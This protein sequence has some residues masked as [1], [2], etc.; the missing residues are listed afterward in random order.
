MPLMT[1]SGQKLLR[2]FISCKCKGTHL[3]LHLLIILVHF[4]FTK[5]VPTLV[6]Q[7]F[8]QQSHIGW[9]TTWVLY[10]LYTS[11]ILHQAE[12]KILVN[13]L[14]ILQKFIKVDDDFLHGSLTF[15]GDRSLHQNLRKI[16]D[17]SVREA[18][19]EC[20]LDLILCQGSG[21][22][23]GGGCFLRFIF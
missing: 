18:C 2:F 9:Q 13:Q 15:Q 20:N 5:R 7:D 23:G 10:L 22:G 12:S 11:I 4:L 17:M 16:M 6:A 3:I 21:L 1:D 19:F 8:Y 14:I